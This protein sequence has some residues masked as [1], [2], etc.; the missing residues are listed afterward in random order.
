MSRS[1]ARGCFPEGGQADG[2]FPEPAAVPSRFKC[3]IDE[4]PDQP[5]RK[6]RAATTPD[7]ARADASY[8]ERLLRH[9]TGESG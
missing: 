7:R 4:A 5:A 9:L 2:C 6:G 3:W 1:R 8:P